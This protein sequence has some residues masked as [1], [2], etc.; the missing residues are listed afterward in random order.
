MGALDLL[1]KVKNIRLLPP[2]DREFYR[3]F[4]ETVDNLMDASSM[5][6]ALFDAPVDERPVI[7]QKIE[8]CLTECNRINESLEDLLNRSQQPPFD[9][10]EITQFNDDAFRIMKH[11]NHA[12]NRYVIYD[13]PTSDKEMRELAPIIHQ[14]CGEIAKAV[15]SLQ[16]DRRIEPFFRAVDRLET[17]ADGIYHEGLRRRFKE[18]RLDRISLEK[19]FQGV[20]ES[21]SVGDILPIIKAN[22][23]YTRHA[24]VFFI[25]RQVYEELE[26][27]IDACTELTGTLRRLVAENV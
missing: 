1:K 14:A 10:S 23:E 13:F 27:S 12:A 5:L 24:A 3:L 9:R 11:V 16:H 20:S 2:R 25:L 17:Q 4:D 7:S 15:K 8:T 18:I 26:R 19:R 22:V 21:S 6:V